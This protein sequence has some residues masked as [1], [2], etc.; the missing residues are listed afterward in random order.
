MARHRVLKEKQ[1]TGKIKV[2]FGEQKVKVPF[3][4]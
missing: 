1:M 3:V 4:E 2:P